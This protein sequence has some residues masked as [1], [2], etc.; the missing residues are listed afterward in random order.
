MSDPRTANEFKLDLTELAGRH[1]ATTEHSSADR[2]GEGAVRERHA[3]HGADR[4]L[5][6]L[7]EPDIGDPVAPAVPQ[8]L[9]DRLCLP[10]RQVP[11]RR[12]LSCR[13]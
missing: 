2:Q 3:S 1:Q 6:T 8:V 10:D 13:A 4:K 12:T 5:E 11:A 7:W 9:G